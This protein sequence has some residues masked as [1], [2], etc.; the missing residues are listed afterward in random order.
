MKAL[1][2]SYQPSNY[3]FNGQEKDDEMFGDGNSYD[4]EARMLD[5]RLGRFLSIDP[6]FA[7]YAGWSPYHF[8]ANSPILI[9]D[10]D[11][12]DWGYSITKDANGV[13]TVNIIFTGVVIVT[14]NTNQTAADIAI[15]IANQYKSVINNSAAYYN[16]RVNPVIT[17]RGITSTAEIKSTDHVIEIVDDELLGSAAGASELYGKQSFVGLHTIDEA[18]V[19]ANKKTI[20][21]ELFH[22]AG[23]R[24]TQNEEEIKVEDKKYPLEI[25][26]MHKEPLGNTLDGGLYQNLMVHNDSYDKQSIDQVINPQQFAIFIANNIA[27]MLNVD[28]VDKKGIDKRLEEKKNKVAGKN[29]TPVKVEQRAKPTAK[30]D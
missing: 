5:V 2:F 1:T 13:T 3:S 6:H 30:E 9:H 20:V 25:V 17:I 26:Q 21:H 11:G 22:T 29:K 18:A 23:F 27:K 8:G 16:V 10:K 28:N 15:L 7:S 14:A 4:F 12:K 24:H 19:G